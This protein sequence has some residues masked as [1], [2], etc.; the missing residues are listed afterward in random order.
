MGKAAEAMAAA[1]NEPD[2]PKKGR[3]GTKSKQKKA[4]SGGAKPQKVGPV[5]ASLTELP[6]GK[7]EV[8]ELI[9]LM[10]DPQMQ[11]RMAIFDEFTV[12]KYKEHYE[13]ATH[14]KAEDAHAPEPW[15]A[16]PALRA[17]DTGEGVI[18]YDGFQRGEAANRAKLEKMW[19]IVTPGTRSD[20]EFYALRANASHGLARSSEDCRRAFFAALDTPDL[21]ARIE[22]KKDEYGGLNRAL[23]ASCGIS[24]GSV[25]NFLRLRGK[26]IRGGK[27]I[28]LPTPV[29]APAPAQ[30]PALS[31]AEQSTH[32]K[33]TATR[34][35]AHEALMLAAKLARVCE[36]LVARTESGAAF[37]RAALDEDV[38]FSLSEDVGTPQIG[39]QGAGVEVE[40]KITWPVL[41]TVIFVLEKVKEAVAEPA[42]AAELKTRRKEVG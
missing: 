24:K 39:A 13:E 38:P 30:P 18:V 14:K 31:E 4:K 36:G 32:I 37:R 42:P 6:A 22:A 35:L 10:F 20:A 8:V 21:Y 3:G 41:D 12:E 27:I 26:T 15:E 40:T 17:I 23:A 1:M 7:T 25:S 29:V 16:L 19:V 11:K 28:N 5:V 2:A 33:L 34:I 9:N